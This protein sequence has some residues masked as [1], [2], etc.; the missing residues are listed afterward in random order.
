[1]IVKFAGGYHGHADL[2]LVQAGSGLITHQQADVTQ[3][4]ALPP[5][6]AGVPSEAVAE[7]TV[8]A[9]NDT[10]AAVDFFKSSGKTVAAVIVEPVAGNM[11][12]VLPKPEFLKTLRTLC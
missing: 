3:N 9:Y 5:S 2:L 4:Q 7:T 11:G 12:V 10:Q 8:L 1:K 6:S